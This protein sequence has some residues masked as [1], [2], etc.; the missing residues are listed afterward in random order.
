LGI[1]ALEDKIVQHVVGAVLS[2]IWEEAFL[3][4]SYGFRPGRNQHNALDALYVGITRW[5]VN[6]VLDLDMQ[7]F[8]DRIEHAWMIKFVEH[9][10]GDRRIVRLMQKWDAAPRRV[11]SANADTTRRSANTQHENV[12]VLG[13]TDPVTFCTPWL[14]H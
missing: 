11:S 10:I 13:P 8:F 9:R 12:F 4:F 2:Q 7:A 5:K 1:A 6:W 3:G 14:H